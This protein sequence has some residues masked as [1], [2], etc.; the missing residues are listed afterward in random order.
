MQLHSLAFNDG[1]SIPKKYTCDASDVSPP[2]TWSAMP[3]GAK[4]LTLTCEDLDG[5]EGSRIHWLLFNLPPDM[6][7]AWLRHWR[8]PG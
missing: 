3:E 2:L 8:F 5:D 6:R 4:S 7:E 1:G